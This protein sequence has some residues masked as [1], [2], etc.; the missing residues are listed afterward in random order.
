MALDSNCQSIDILCL[1]QLL[2]IVYLS[3]PYPSKS[4]KQFFVQ[5]PYPDIS[6]GLHSYFINVRSLIFVS[7]YQVKCLSQSQ[8]NLKIVFFS[9]YNF[10]RH[11]YLHVLIWFSEGLDRSIVEQIRLKFLPSMSP[12]LFYP[13]LVF[14]TCGYIHSHS[15][16]LIDLQRV[17]LC[18]GWIYGTFKVLGT[19]N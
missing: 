8:H 10:V 2:V 4:L 6:L 12:C 15:L 16:R 19:G 13:Y 7:T 3:H 18:D 11:F 1:T 9:S 17:R 14:H 5:E